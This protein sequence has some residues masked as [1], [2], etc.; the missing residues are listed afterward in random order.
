MILTIAPGSNGHYRVDE[1]GNVYTRT[2]FKID[3][4]GHRG[5]RP[6]ER[7]LP[8]SERPPAYSQYGGGHDVALF[9]LPTGQ[10]DN[11]EDEQVETLEE[12]RAALDARWMAVEAREQEICPECGKAASRDY[13]ITVGG[14][15]P[16][17]CVERH[18]S[19]DESEPAETSGKDVPVR[20]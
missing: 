7:P 14:R 9:W 16:F 8:F 18:I 20:L 1:D 12:A 2:G 11:L 6:G 5:P 4:E 13:R 3:P 15:I 10:H 17:V 19:V